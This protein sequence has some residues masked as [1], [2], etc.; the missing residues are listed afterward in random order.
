[1]TPRQDV[2]ERRADA[3]PILRRMAERLA[4]LAGWRRA[5]AAFLC[6]LLAA[7]ALPPLHLLPLLIPAFTG[8]LWLLDGVSR[9]RD[10][11]LLGW[12]FGLGFF[13]AGLYW[14][15]IA[16]TVD[17]ARFGWFMPV[18]V[19]GL[20]AGLSLFIGTA[21][22]LVWESRFEGSARILLL[23]AAWLAAEFLRSVLLTGFPWNL[24]GSV[25]AF[26]PA[27]LQAAAL[28]G[29]WGLG[30]FTLLAAAAPAVLAGKA[31]ASPR[32]A[33]RFLAT[34]WLLLLLLVCSGLLRLEFAAAPGEDVQADVRLRLVQPSIPQDEKWRGELQEAHLQRHLQLSLDAAPQ[35]PTHIIWPE[36]AIPWY[37][38]RETQLTEALGSI[39]PDGGALILGA[40]ALEADSDGEPLIYN[41]VYVLD[42]QGETLLRYDKYHLVPFGEFLPF[43]DLLS[44]LGM[45]KVTE[46]SLDFARGTGAMTAELPGLPPS[47]PLV[48][49]EVIFSGQVTAAEEERPAW[50]L[51]LTNDAWFGRSS[52][53]YQ[54]FA[55]ARLRAVEEGLPLVRAAN[56]GISAVVDPY[57]RVLVRLAQDEIAAVDSPLPSPLAPTPYAR[58]GRLWVPLLLILLLGGAFLLREGRSTPRPSNR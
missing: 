13:V 14:V 32:G 48:C 56:N 19:M 58:L 41:S 4:G 31:A 1:M 38:N 39:V 49:Y 22:W 17:L 25:W 27:P 12:C 35:A 34:S 24:L 18:S 51:N 2:L 44:R 6:G 21:L 54:H 29:V 7:A 55:S 26:H 45:E 53:P 47:S 23:A 10:A 46:G 5:L 37:L 50:L 9:R 33:R 40:P 43:R 16:M 36:T 28:F 57:G 11:F 3:P 15:G 52:G 42:E 8:L 20:S 30:V